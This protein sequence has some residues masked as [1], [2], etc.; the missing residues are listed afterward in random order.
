M[1][2]NH[3]WGVPKMLSLIFLFV[4]PAWAG[5]GWYLLVPPPV[6]GSKGQYLEID[7]PI[8]LWNQRSAH[9]TARECQDQLM[10]WDE[11]AEKNMKDKDKLER[12]RNQVAFARCIASDDPR[13][14]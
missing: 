14:K 3:R 4:L 10:S 13:L 8:R 11:W 5:Q 1:V 2:R 6:K 7:A 9:D 12:T